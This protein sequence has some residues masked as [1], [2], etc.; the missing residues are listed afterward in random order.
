MIRKAAAAIAAAAAVT[1]LVIGVTAEA[2]AA[3][4]RHHAAAK[5]HVVAKKAT[6]KKSAAK[7]VTKSAK[8]AKRVHKDFESS[9]R[10]FGL[11]A[12]SFSD[13]AAVTSETGSAPNQYTEFIKWN[14]NASENEYSSFPTAIA[15]QLAAEGVT[16]EVTWMSQDSASSVTAQP[17]AYTD[18][19][20]A[21]GSQDAYLTSWANAIKAFGQPV[22][23]R[24]D[25]EM[26]GNWEAY[27]PG[28]NGN[29]ADSFI[30]MWRHVVNVFRSAGATNAIWSWSPNAPGQPTSLP[31][32]FPGGSYVDRVGIDNYNW[33]TTQTASADGWNSR[34]ESASDVFGAGVGQLESLAPNKPIYLE[35][36]GSAEQGGSKAAWIQGMWSYLASNTEIR[37][38]TWFDFDKEADWRIDSSASS[39]AAFKAGVA[40]YLRS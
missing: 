10:V 7:K 8:V 37:G 17:A 21:A 24:L 19:A 25:P 40:G 29:T 39:A 22:V 18:A 28:N 6:V 1:G 26:N 3:T 5:S 33:G 35:E 34:W 30:A 16:L 36:T 14:W 4:P 20:I 27:S 38:F 12:D 11:A 13:I 32:V 23:I 9:P 2:N 31:A 15:Q